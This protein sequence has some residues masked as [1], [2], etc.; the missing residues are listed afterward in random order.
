VASSDGQEVRVAH[1][2]LTDQPEHVFV[3]HRHVV[4]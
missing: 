2:S 1:L 4:D 3:R